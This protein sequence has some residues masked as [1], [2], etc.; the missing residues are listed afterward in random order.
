MPSTNASS[1]SASRTAVSIPAAWS[2]AI[3]SRRAAA[4]VSG[5]EKATPFAHARE[6]IDRAIDVLARVR[7]GELHANS[8]LTLRHD[9]VA[10]ADDVDA[11]VEEIARH[12]VRHPRVAD[13]DRDDRMLTGLD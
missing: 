5:G 6:R 8:R 1:R 13:H 12:L 7:R 4:R 11:L 3:A 9:R 2:V 10:E